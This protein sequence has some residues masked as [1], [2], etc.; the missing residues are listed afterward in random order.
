MTKS[1][2][3]VSNQ[4]KR[5]LLDG[6]GIAAGAHLYAQ[7]RRAPPV[8]W[9]PVGTTGPTLAWLRSFWTVHAR[10]RSRR[11]LGFALPF[12]PCALGFVGATGSGA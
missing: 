11:A 7:F 1:G 8:S 5:L 9:R 10:T 12:E 3:Y 2:S 6:W 4:A